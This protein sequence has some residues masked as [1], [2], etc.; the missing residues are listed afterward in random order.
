[1]S[2]SGKSL[3]YLALDLA[4][5]IALVAMAIY[6]FGWDLSFFGYVTSAAVNEGPWKFFA[7]GIASSF[8]VLVG[9]GLVLAHQNGIRW[10]GFWK[11]WLKIAG[12]ALLITIATYYFT[13]DSFIFFGILH[14]IAFAS[15]AGLLFLRLHLLAL[16]ALGIAL[17]LVAPH[18][19]FD[20][21]NGLHLAWTGLQSQGVRSNDYV[22][23]FPW[24]GAA[25]IGMGLGK[26]ALNRTLFDHL[27]NIPNNALTGCLSFLGR[28]SLVTY[29]VHQPILIAGIYVF[30]LIY[31][32]QI[33]EAALQSQFAVSCQKSCGL[34]QNARR[35]AFYCG[36]V[37]SELI[38]ADLFTPVMT[39]QIDFASGK[40]AAISQQCSVEMF[41]IPG[42]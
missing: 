26:L 41:D 33:D 1:M 8:L 39:G 5:G 4:R 32:A 6:H 29:L 9:I 12:A 7:R 16:V 13:P 17:I 2:V 24:F 23:V 30:S 40:P 36:C 35:C 21:L 11:R 14:Q 28:H 31:P 19:K 20:A 18:L 22:P 37:Q 42:Q 25:L 15:L 10:A 3:R 34:E 38:E 27:Q